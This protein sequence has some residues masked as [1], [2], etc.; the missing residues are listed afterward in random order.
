[1]RQPAGHAGASGTF[2]TPRWGTRGRAL[3]QLPYIGVTC[4]PAY[5]CGQQHAPFER[6]RHRTKHLRVQPGTM[7]PQQSAHTATATRAWVDGSIRFAHTKHRTAPRRVTTACAIL[8]FVLARL[9]PDLPPRPGVR[10]R[11][12]YQEMMERNIPPHMMTFP[13]LLRLNRHR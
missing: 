2:L 1:M 8:T 13:T 10:R 5:E 6:H 12:H 7:A 3:P 11:H 4:A 9:P